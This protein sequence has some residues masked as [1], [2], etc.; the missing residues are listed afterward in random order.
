M[1][2]TVYPVMGA[3]LYQTQQPQLISFKT[4]TYEEELL[5]LTFSLV[6]PELVGMMLTGSSFKHA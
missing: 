6:R 2:K 1:N 4:L 5:N 3:N